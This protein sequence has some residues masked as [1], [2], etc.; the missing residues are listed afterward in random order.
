MGR[1]T[2]L[3][4]PHLTVDASRRARRALC[5][6]ALAGAA[7]QACGAA[8]AHASW[9][10]P[11]SAWLDAVYG[12]PEPVWFAPSGSRPASAEAL[13]LLRAAPEH[14][15]PVDGATLARIERA[16]HDASAPGADP[17]AVMRADRAL[18]RAMLGHL[19]DLRF[20]R[21]PPA[22]VAPHYRVPEREAPF[23]AGL[24]SAAA[25]GRLA[26]LVDAAAPRFAQY[27]RL[28]TVLGHYR[29]LAGNAGDWPP[30]PRR[31][32]VDA[33]EAY[34]G[35]DALRA[36]L[37]ALGD[38]AAD[39]PPAH[40]RYTPALVAAVARF[41][42]R[43]GLAPDGVLGRLTF[44]A[45]DV[46]PSERVAQIGLSLERIRWLPDP[47]PGPLVAVNIPSYRLWAFAD[48][49]ADERPRLSMAVVVGRAAR[50]Q[51]PVFVGTMRHVEFSPYWNVPAS[52]VRDEYLGPLRRDP[53]RLARED[54]EIVPARGGGEPLVA[55][56]AAALAG[57]RDG[58]LRLRQRP[59]PRNAL[60]GAKFVLP[61][62]MQ[63]YL[64]GTPAT[65]LFERTRR[66]FSH[67]CIR[68][69]EPVA[70]AR[71]VLEGRPEWTQDAIVAAMAART[72]RTVSLPV[73]VPVVV[74][75]TTTVV[76]EAGRAH[77][78]PDVYGHD[79]R[80][81]TALARRAS[82]PR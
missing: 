6:L 2:T 27:R 75:Y 58:A 38:L 51:T 46:P 34:D 56:D 52:I 65:A 19:A 20:G 68:V 33:G 67:G 79:A 5:V 45:L 42:A 30:L 50:S 1:A 23:V 71:F 53:S 32:R 82:G 76:D 11:E 64:H 40:G 25:S 62:A 31:S 13:R 29:D 35:A 21:V 59:G 57:L 44:A 18:T 47:A 12:T 3:M 14:G 15:L 24:R 4:D 55:A 49:V 16:L 69:A 17:Q 26:A 8:P 10:R 63:V 36:R 41:Q 37:V 39:A 60:G 22:E 48:A 81:A 54:M 80:L 77:F 28:R 70:L 78:L 73:A 66:D 74:F 9:E 7:V 61:N 72:P 43:H